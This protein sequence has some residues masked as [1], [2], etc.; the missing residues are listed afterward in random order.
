MHFTESLTENRNFMRLYR[1]GKNAAGAFVAVYSKRNNQGINRLGITVSV[2]L[3]GA[4]VRNRIR[5]RIREAY[6]VHE[7]EFRKGF[8]IVIVARH[9]A[10]AESFCVFEQAICNA[11]RTLGIMKDKK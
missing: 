5:R 9:R 2:K 3:G 8:D 1:T 10:K 11:F 7:T 4:V 6:R